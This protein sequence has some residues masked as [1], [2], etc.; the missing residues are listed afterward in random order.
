MLIAAL[1]TIA[2]TWKQSRCPLADEWI[3]KLVH[4]PNGIL[5]SYKKEHFWVSFNEVDETGAYYTEWCKAEIETPIQYVNAYI[6]FP[7]GSEVKCL[8][9]MW[10]TRV[11]SLGWEDPLEKEMVTH[12]SILAWRIPWTEKPGR[13]QSMGSQRV[14]H[15]WVTSLTHSL[16]LLVL[17]YTW[18]LWFTFW[19]LL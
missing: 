13:L 4:K 19:L 3:R 1:F 11:R 10:E 16:T 9:P 6:V 14:G 17:E 8:P 18:P 15:D 2:R 12:S 7:G 5:L